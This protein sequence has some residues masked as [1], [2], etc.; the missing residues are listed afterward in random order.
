MCG[1][2]LPNNRGR[3]AFDAST[4]IYHLGSIS[5]YSLFAIFLCE[6]LSNWLWLKEWIQTYG[7][8]LHSVIKINPITRETSSPQFFCLVSEDKNVVVYNLNWYTGEHK[9]MAFNLYPL[10]MVT[11]I[12]MITQDSLWAKSWW[13]ASLLCLF[14]SYTTLSVMEV[15]KIH[16]SYGF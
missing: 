2:Q 9:F 12:I 5:I 15:R 10:K 6:F 16:Q 14:I 1:V 13:F 3:Q 8:K 4:P 7:I 11:I